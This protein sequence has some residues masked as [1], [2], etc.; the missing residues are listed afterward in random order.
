LI[1]ASILAGIF[2]PRLIWGQPSPSQPLAAPAPPDLVEW[3]FLGAVGTA[4][5]VAAL[6]VY[7]VV[8][9]TG[10]FTFDY[11][12]PFMKTFGRRVLLAHFLCATLLSNG[13]SLIV[14][15]F[16]TAILWVVIPGKIAIE[17][18]WLIPALVSVF[19]FWL[20]LWIWAPLDLLVINRRMR[21][22]GVPP[23][24]IAAGLPIGTSDPDRKRRWFAGMVE[25]DVGLLWFDAEQLTYFGDLGPWA[26]TRDQLLSI[27]RLAHKRALA[28][29]FGVIHVV[30]QFRRPDGSESR[31]LLF[32]EGNWTQFRRAPALNRLADRLISWREGAIPQ[33]PAI[34]F[35][36]IG[37]GGN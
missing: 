26:I 30:L 5:I 22:L 36:V 16:L 17:L 10:C 11:Q 35:A 23:D 13:S 15:P 32:T 27:D 4:M 21:A 29:H 25:E 8:L 19:Y 6:A 3:I 20:F 2:G 9:L 24:R 18:G 12:R 34:G 14:A 1:V 33:L 7:G 37:A 28:S 31:V